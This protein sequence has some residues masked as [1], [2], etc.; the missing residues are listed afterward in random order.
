MYGDCLNSLY[1]I[2]IINCT[3]RPLALTVTLLFVISNINIHPAFDIANSD[4]N[5][6]TFFVFY[7]A[8]FDYNIGDGHSKSNNCNTELFNLPLD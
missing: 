6:E 7:N 5:N 4:I 8:L 2:S 1:Y 3:I